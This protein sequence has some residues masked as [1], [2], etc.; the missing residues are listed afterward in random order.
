MKDRTWNKIIFVIMAIVIGYFA[1]AT[2]K[3]DET[4]QTVARIEVVIAGCAAA[5]AI[6]GDHLDN[7]YYFQE[8]KRWTEY[9]IGFTNYNEGKSHEMIR[10]MVTLGLAN[11]SDGSVDF[12]QF[13]QVADVHCIQIRDELLK[14]SDATIDDWFGE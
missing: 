9:L 6:V 11:L 10:E 1:I 14:L 2:A 12:E 8:G 5:N 7:D 3:A 4:D 13:R